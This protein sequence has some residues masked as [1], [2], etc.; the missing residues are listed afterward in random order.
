MKHNEIAEMLRNEM[1]E[2]GISPACW[3]SEIYNFAA[4][5]DGNSRGSVQ[6]HIKI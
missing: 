6:Y 3:D 1:T 4:E 2:R 5:N